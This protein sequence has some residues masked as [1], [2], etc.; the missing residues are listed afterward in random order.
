MSG[1]RCRSRPCQKR[2]SS[3]TPNF[4]PKS[5]TLFTIA[6]EL[7][8]KLPT[9]PLV[10]CTPYQSISTP[11][12]PAVLH[13]QHVVLDDVRIARG[14]RTDLGIVVRRDLPPAGRVDDVRVPSRELPVVAPVRS[15]QR[16][17]RLE[18]GHVVHVDLHRI[19]LCRRRPAAATAA[20]AT[21]RVRRTQKDDNDSPEGAA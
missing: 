2:S 5:S 16:R 17:R 6:L 19:G 3:T 15:A 8:S 10:P 11:S 7:V 20:G 14:V 1:V 13:Q 4:S 9:S 12:T 18:P 21:A